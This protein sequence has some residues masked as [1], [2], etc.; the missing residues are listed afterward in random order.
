[1][2]KT[3]RK[4]DPR[5]LI[6]A[7]RPKLPFD[8]YPIPAAP[9]LGNT[10]IAI[11]APVPQFPTAAVNFVLPTTRIKP[12][13]IIYVYDM[14]IEHQD[15]AVLLVGSSFERQA[16]EDLVPWTIY[17]HHQLPGVAMPLVIT[18][19]TPLP[20]PF[21]ADAI[22]QYTPTLRLGFTA[23][24][25]AAKPVAVNLNWVFYESDIPLGAA[26][27]LAGAGGFARAGT[28]KRFEVSE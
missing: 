15:A 20:F 23:V 7:T 19:G 16:P 11:A 14:V 26:F 22:Y 1:M 27:G 18:F 13:G 6:P 4:I 28:Y 2:Q 10:E 3:T 17:N 25:A 21:G 12:R 8:K 24:G 5:E 9:I